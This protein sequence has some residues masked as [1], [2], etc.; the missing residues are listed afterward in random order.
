[1]NT[2]KSL[3][4]EKL[5]K[6]KQNLD[7]NRESK[8]D[9][10]ELIE[11][12]NIP[13]NIENK[14]NYLIVNLDP[15]KL[16]FTL[17]DI[18]NDTIYTSNF[19]NQIESLKLKENDIKYLKVTKKDKNTIRKYTYN[20][21]K[22]TPLIVNYTFIEDKYKINFERINNN[23]LNEE[24]PNKQ[25][26]VTYYKKIND[27]DILLGTEIARKYQI[28]NNFELYH[29]VIDYK[30]ERPH[31]SFWF[32]DSNNITYGIN[33]SKNKD[34]NI[35]LSGI[36]FRKTPLNLKRYHPCTL[37]LDKFQELKK[38]RNI[39]SLL[40]NGVSD[41]NEYLLEIY[42]DKNR[43]LL[44]YSI[45]DNKI[46]ITSDYKMILPIKEEKEITITEI[47]YIIFL[48]KAKFNDQFTN[49]VIYE[50]TTFK[51]LTNLKQI[52]TIFNANTLLDL[53][54]QK[55]E[56]YL[57][58]NKNHYLSLIKSNI[59]DTLKDNNKSPHK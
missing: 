55:L 37:N 46:N 2:I 26:T 27:K 6:I 30:T 22:T 13:I 50:L 31:N 9:F 52:E 47:D 4:E 38:T 53:D 11:L 20:A 23:I 15:I 44:K 35:N 42:K 49:L 16:E 32:I 19:T 25:L 43:F 28:D 24:I 51:T 12:F 5:T 21:Y 56:A 59:T 34:S 3:L 57:S 58:L 14:A 48:L 18:F 36:C 29:Q 41:D 7:D 39:S 45:T 1:M 33:K 10:E 54:L 17:Y 40:F 8:K